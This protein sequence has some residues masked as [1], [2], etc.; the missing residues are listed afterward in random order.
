MRDRLM[1]LEL[2]QTVFACVAAAVATLA[3]PAEAQTR[4]L[5]QVGGWRSYIAEHA[6]GAVC[7]VSTA[8]RDGTAVHL[9]R[10]A[11]EP[12]VYMQ[13]FNTDWRSVRDGER[14]ALELL[15]DGGRGRAFEAAALG[16]R[17]E[18]L[19]GVNFELDLD[20][21]RAFER[22]RLLSIGLRDRRGGVRPLTD[23]DLVGSGRALR[24]LLDCVRG[25]LAE[26]GAP[27]RGP[28]ERFTP[29]APRA[30]AR[31]EAPERAPR[32][33]APPGDGDLIPI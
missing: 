9:T 28:S 32:F 4:T 2:R 17:S 6:D 30:P 12:A 19:F 23:V 25:P 18:A 27:G 3:G 20:R 26:R 22:A 21:L 5:D 7:G 8:A 29:P 14:Y 31:P 10:S 15:F 24:A 1:R 33:D 13:V 16:V 11:D